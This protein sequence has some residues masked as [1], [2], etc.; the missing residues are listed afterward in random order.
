MSRRWPFSLPVRPQRIPHKTSSK[1]SG[2][3]QKQARNVWYIKHGLSGF[4]Q[5]RIRMSDVN[6]AGGS[7][8]CLLRV[9]VFV[10]LALYRSSACNPSICTLNH[11]YHRRQNYSDCAA[12]WTLRE[13]SHS[14]GEIL[15]AVQ[16]GR[17]ALPTSC[18][19]GTWSSLGKPA[20]AWC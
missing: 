12:G 13:S 16:T 17:E 14:E 3:L 10:F 6:C 7:A 11:V 9:L 1:R 8:V 18:S 5:Y 19:I 4:P 15:R 2:G 20:G